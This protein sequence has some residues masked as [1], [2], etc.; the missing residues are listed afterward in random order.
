MKDRRHLNEVIISYGNTPSTRG[1][2]S[3]WNVI[4]IIGTGKNIERVYLEEDFNFDDL[5]EVESRWVKYIGKM[6]VEMQEAI[7]TKAII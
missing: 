4:G 1:K 2:T 7:K 3:G 5:K 6:W